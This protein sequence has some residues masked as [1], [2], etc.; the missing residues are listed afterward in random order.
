MLDPSRSMTRIWKVSGL[1]AFAAATSRTLDLPGYKALPIHQAI[2]AIM[3][4]K[5]HILES[6]ASILQNAHRST[7]S[8]RSGVAL[9]IWQIE[10]RLKNRTKEMTRS[11]SVHRF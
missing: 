2:K 10:D 5:R 8:R 7:G 6:A 3:T 4:S 9:Q 11:G 1:R